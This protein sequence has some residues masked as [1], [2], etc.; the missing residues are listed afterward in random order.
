VESS[1]RFSAFE[2]SRFQVLW[3]VG[4]CVFCRRWYVEADGS[5]RAV[6][7]VLPAAGQPAAATLD[8]LA[9]E[10]GLKDVLDGSWAA[11]PL[12]FVR[13]RGRTMLVLEEQGGEPLGRLL[14]APME[15]GR[16]LHL[17]IGITV[18]LGK[19]HQA[20]LVHK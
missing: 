12:E 1:S 6:L 4:D 18:A 11:R 16:F 15:V 19:V 9:H 10:Y 7:A 3:E 14:G 8:R 17:A 5:R 20:G 13:D 2:D